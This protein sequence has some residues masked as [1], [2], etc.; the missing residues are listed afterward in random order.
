MPRTSCPVPDR[1][2]PGGGRSASAPSR[3]RAAEAFFHLG[4]GTNIIYVDP[5][6]DLVI[7]MRW[8]AGTAAADGVVRRVLAGIGR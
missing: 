3:G 1:A 7:V 2:R 6:H 5:V 8:I 4:A